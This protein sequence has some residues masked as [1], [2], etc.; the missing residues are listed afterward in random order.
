M[1]YRSLSMTVCLDAPIGR[2]RRQT[3]QGCQDD[4]IDAICSKLCKFGLTSCSHG[5]HAC[6]L[7]TLIVYPLEASW[8]ACAGLGEIAGSKLSSRVGVGEVQ[9]T[10][11]ATFSGPGVLHCFKQCRWDFGCWGTHVSLVA[12]RIQPSLVA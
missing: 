11:T 1:S 7:Y 5:D 2:G 10:P 12:R 9:W 8:P 4:V 6:M 3:V